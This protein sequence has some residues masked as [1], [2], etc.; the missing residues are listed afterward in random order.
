MNSIILSRHSD[1]SESK[2]RI[3]SFADGGRPDIVT[4][5]SLSATFLTDMFAF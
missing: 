3:V 1:G 2:T 4:F 5:P